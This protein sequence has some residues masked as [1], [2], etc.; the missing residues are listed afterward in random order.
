MPEFLSQ[1]FTHKLVISLVITG[2]L[3]LARTLL[4]RLIRRE[5][6]ILT[7]SQRRWMSRAK[8][9][10]ILLLIITLTLLWWPEIHRF[11]LSIAAVAVAFVIA[12][13]ELILCLSGAVLRAVTGAAS[14]GDWIEIAN[15]R[16]EV[17]DQSMLSVTIQEIDRDN[18][19]YDFTGKTIV[20]PNSLFLTH[21]VKNMNYMRRFVFHNFSI[22]T[23][24][25]LNVFEA[26]QL[27]LDRLEEYSTEFAELGKRYNAFVEKRLGVDLPNPEPSV[28]ITTTALG[29]NLFSITFFCPTREA[30]A[31]EQQIMQDFMTFYYKR[32]TELGID[33]SKAGD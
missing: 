11:A 30:V 21:V 33:K 12:G 5:A 19:G 10:V 4:I 28:R 24:P 16:G 31:L 27:I 32:K 3:L 22:S 9:S 15:H 23:E 8:N 14:V 20:L 25:N 26:R 1:L 17:V 6:D 29:K 2:L 18:N 7:E 13:K